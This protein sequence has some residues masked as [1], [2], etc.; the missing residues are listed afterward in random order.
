LK[1][2]DVLG[3]PVYANAKKLGML[4][5]IMLNR[6]DFKIDFFIV[7]G[8]TV[9]GSFIVPFFSCSIKEDRAVLSAEGDLM[10]IDSFVLYNEIKRS[11]S[12]FTTKNI[13]DQDENVLG[14]IADY[15]FDEQSGILDNITYVSVTGSTESLNFSDVIDNSKEAIRINAPKQKIED[16]IIETPLDFDKEFLEPQRQKDGATDFSSLEDQAR[17]AFDSFIRDLEERKNRFYK[18]CDSLEAELKNRADLPKTPK[19]EPEPSFDKTPR[20]RNLG[21]RNLNERNLSERN[22]NERN[23]NERNL[24]ERSFSERSS[25]E[26]TSPERNLNE[27]SSSPERIPQGNLQERTPPE[28]KTSPVSIPTEASL[29]EDKKPEEIPAVPKSAE[30]P[31]KPLESG[32]RKDLEKLY[33]LQ[34]KRM[35]IL[36]KL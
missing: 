9:N 28:R 14:K 16:P 1:R 5:E 15:E 29:P 25:P 4:K 22:L 26:R 33:E 13:I 10:A 18:F 20:E 31:T 17:E 23:L 6:E 36:K 2:K 30:R 35:S 24:S 27:R 12:I 21:E 8:S 19:F 3:L 7:L 34:R 11:E 32:S